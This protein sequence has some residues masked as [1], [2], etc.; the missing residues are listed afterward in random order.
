MVRL[1]LARNQAYP[2]YHCHKTNVFISY[3]A[4]FPGG[5]IPYHRRPCAMAHGQQRFRSPCSSRRC[6]DDVMCRGINSA[7]VEF[8]HVRFNCAS[9]GDA[10]LS[11]HQIYLYPFKLFLVVLRMLLVLCYYYSISS[12]F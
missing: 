11:S 5:N 8:K 6:R 12:L 2:C 7:S 4:P 9:N 1:I 10:D 3:R